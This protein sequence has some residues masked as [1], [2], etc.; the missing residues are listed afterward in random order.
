MTL[1]AVDPVAPSRG[2]TPEPMAALRIAY[3][4]NMYPSVSHTFI[5]RELQELERRGHHILRIAIRTSDNAIPDPQDQAEE[6]RTVH[7][8]SLPKVQLAWGAIRTMATSPIGFLLALRACIMLYRRSD[9]GLARHVAYLIEAAFLREFARKQRIRHIHVH[10]GTNPAAVALLARHMGGPPYSITIHGPEEFDA[11]VG[12]S[13]ADK[14]E[15]ASFIAAIS[16]F[17][18]AQVKR[19][20]PL[21]LW[22]RVHI[23]GC[24]V[25]DQF[26]NAA[27]PVNPESRTL[28]CIGRFNAQKGH[29]ELIAAFAR[30]IAS[31]IDARLVLAGDGELRREIQ[32]HVA[33]H[34][35]ESR[36]EITGWIPESEVRRQIGQCR[37]LVMASFAEGLPMVLMEAFALGRAVIATSIAGIPEL[38]KPNESGWLVPAGDTDALARAMKEVLEAPASKLDAMA[39][40][41]RREVLARHST[42]IE[43]ARLEAQILKAV[44]G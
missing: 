5:R 43:A 25:G 16:S 33:R 32:E 21:R 8:L 34:K 14:I 44:Q 28:L 1:A 9:R 10:F 41:G 15:S 39:A 17:A 7:V 12:L 18:A 29:L 22:D 26:F 36:V 3:L 38:V 31:G 27:T 4:V 19:W 2:C 11:P 30:V 20:I 37:A 13:L 35:L 40:A 6:T 42:P 23:V 24:T